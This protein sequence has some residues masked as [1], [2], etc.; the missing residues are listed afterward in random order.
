MPTYLHPGVYIEEIPSGAKPIEGVSTSTAAFI[1][2]TVKGT[3][4]E[5][6]LISKW[7]DYLDQYGGIRDVANSL[8][9][10]TM[11]FSVSAFFQN[12][13]RKAYI[14]RLAEDDSP[15][16]P[17][18]EA[19]GYMTSPEDSAKDLEFTAVNEGSW[20]DGLIARL[21]VKPSDSS[22]YTLEIGRLDSRG[23]LGVL[24]K[25]PD[26]SLDS[27]SVRYIKSAVDD[28]SAYVTVD[29]VDAPTDLGDYP[30]GYLDIL[31]GTST[32]GDLSALDLDLSAAAQSARELT[33]SLDGT[34]AFTIEIAQQV[35]A[36]LDALAA[37]I[38]SEVRDGPAVT[39]ERRKKFTCV[40]ADDKLV[41]TSGTRGLD[42]S[43]AVT[44]GGLAT[45]LSLGA[46][47]VSGEDLLIAM[48]ASGDSQLVDGGDGVPAADTAYDDVFTKFL[49]IRD[50]SVICLPD[51]AW[52]SDGKT[53]IEKAISHA[54][55]MKSRMV[56]VDP[57]AGDE[58][59][60]EKEVSDL[61]LPTS[62]YT[63]LYYPWVKVANPFYDEDDNPGALTTLLVP[64]SGYAAGMWSKIDGRRGVWKAPAGVETQLL[65]VSAL[66][67]VVEDPEQDILNPLG[68][69]AFRRQPSF[70]NVIWGARTL[71]TKADPEWR[72]VPVRRTAIFIEQ[73]IYGGIQWAVFEP[74]DHRLW[75]SLRLNIES[76]MD[77][78]H[79]S[80]AFQGE[81]AS[82]AYFVR[83]GL[84]DTMTQGEID[85]GQV[86][87]IVGFAP[88]KPAEFVIVRIQQK[89]AQQ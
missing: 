31:T 16:D 15:D 51:K 13:G 64:P 40:A 42:S 48:L 52:D 17:L 82:D 8:K 89:V 36:D 11:G 79:R 37:E 72:Y 85:R 56:V 5:A 68:V 43:T 29:I 53:V 84:G 14:V 75:A 59:E 87:V 2:Y 30:D 66:A 6:E 34:T 41:L 12:G 83:C 81:K 7:D 38:Q 70:G 67:A 71:S 58:L 77:G 49:K 60:T 74:N 65:G 78:L 35:Y 33:M 50:I 24:E 55:T 47:E 20:A 25:F 80:G 4:G 46:N 27:T 76:F 62:T 21:T 19:V 32:S 61:G 22:L 26:V 39:T 54:E 63:A 23:E 57:P 73:S 18:V 9:G 44:G 28:I 3:V 45:T 86:I 69:N 10:D 1:G 88:L